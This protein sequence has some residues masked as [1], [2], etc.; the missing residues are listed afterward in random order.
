MRAIA[1]INRHSG[2]MRTLDPETVERTLT[3]IF[4]GRGHTLSV[5]FVES[6]AIEDRLREALSQR[7]D[8]VIV[9]GGDGTVNTAACLLMGTGVALGILPLGTMNLFARSL[10]IPVDLTAAAEALAGAGVAEADLGT[11]GERIFIHQVGFGIQPRMARL[12]SRTDYDGRIGKLLATLKALGGVL[13]RPKRLPVALLVDG[14]ERGR[15]LTGL[16][17]SNNPYG[18]GHLPYADHVGTGLLGAYATFTI[19]PRALAGLF[20]DVL[21]GTFQANPNLQTWTGRSVRLEATRS[22]MAAI[23]ATVDGELVQL[24]LPVLVGKRPS[25]LKVLVPEGA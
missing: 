5:V 16:A 14:V 20:L 12:R 7:P 13:A 6:D 1:L 21:R 8:A 2:T 22:G 11:V 19:R 23:Q 18:E 24:D 9:G 15:R 3:E 4:A 17:V 25:A 10:R